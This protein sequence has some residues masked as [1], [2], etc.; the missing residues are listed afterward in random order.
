MSTVK[1]NAAVQGRSATV[2]TAAR[3]NETFRALFTMQRLQLRSSGEGGPSST[4]V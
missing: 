3:K 4:V 1:P 2:P